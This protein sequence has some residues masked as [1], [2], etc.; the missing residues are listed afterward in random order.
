MIL[1]EFD[2]VDGEYILDGLKYNSY[3]TNFDVSF[4]EMKLGY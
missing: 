3:I 2:D 1:N 4:N